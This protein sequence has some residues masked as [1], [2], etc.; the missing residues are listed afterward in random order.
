[1]QD[2]YA[3]EDNAK[4]TEV[5]EVKFQEKKSRSVRLSSSNAN[6]FA[7]RNWKI[8]KHPNILNNPQYLCM[9]AWDQLVAC[10]A[11]A[12]RGSSGSNA[13]LYAPSGMVA[14]VNAIS[15]TLC[16]VCAW[17]QELCWPTWEDTQQI[18]PGQG[19]ESSSKSP[20][21]GLLRCLW[22]AKPKGVCNLCTDLGRSSPVLFSAPLTM[23]SSV[24]ELHWDHM[25]RASPD[26]TIF[27]KAPVNL[28]QLKC[29]KS[30]SLKADEC[31]KAKYLSCCHLK[32]PVV[33]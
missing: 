16:I 21:W 27:H 33:N 17:S 1:M 32:W 11:W 29:C 3:W 20:S 30:S 6:R 24:P 10:S 25:M 14:K 18:L 13:I 8:S 15:I 12:H 2:Q 28:A 4:L 22:G 31:P 9:L 5:I 19:Q 7:V 23:S 26:S